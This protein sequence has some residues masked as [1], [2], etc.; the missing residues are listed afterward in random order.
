MA[1]TK[2]TRGPL[3]L[4]AL[5]NAA[6]D[7]L[8]RYASSRASLKRVLGRRVARAAREGRIDAT[9]GA[10]LIE[11]ILAR[12]VASGLLDDAAYATQQAASLHRRGASAG[13]VRAR[14]MQK[15]VDA[16]AIGTAL[17][18]LKA[19]SGGDLTAACALVRRRRLGPFRPPASRAATR[20]RDL[21]ILAR[22]GFSH[23]IA[24]RVL[25]AADPDALD[26]IAAGED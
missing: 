4:A 2:P 24:R 10:R 15:G 1:A 26:R 3:T 9:E 22:A 19:E 14:L 7:Y 6:L 11:D 8:A 16:D 20:D 23:A 5:E 18:G 21:G 13:G 12:H 25:S 17:A